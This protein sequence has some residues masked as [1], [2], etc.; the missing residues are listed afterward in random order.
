MS[1]S[2]FNVSYHA[3]KFNVVIILYFIVPPA[4]AVVLT[5]S[6]DPPFYW[7]TTLTLT[8]VVNYD[9][10]LVDTP[11]SFN[12]SITGPDTNAVN[13]T[14]TNQSYVIFRP[15]LPIHNG[16]YNCISI[17]VSNSDSTFISPSRK[18]ISSSFFLQ[19]TGNNNTAL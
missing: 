16:T 8:C 5:H 19:L 15:L 3:L 13:V 14:N 18:S 12:I 9:T 11:V 10:Q 4:T 7:G 2:L 6:R 1:L 17:I